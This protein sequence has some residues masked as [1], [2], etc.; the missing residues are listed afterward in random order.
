MC[1]WVFF[2]HN[3]VLRLSVEKKVRKVLST[4]T[5]DFDVVPPDKRG[6]EGKDILLLDHWVTGM[7]LGRE[8]HV[9]TE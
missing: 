7:S 1:F 2:R 6:V 9:G 3:L 8:P 5:S 4:F